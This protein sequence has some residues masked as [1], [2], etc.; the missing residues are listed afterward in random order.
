[1]P[2]PSSFK[3]RVYLDHHATTP[4]DPDVVQVMDRYWGMVGQPRLETE[5]LERAT[6]LV[7]T[8]LGVAVPPGELIWTSGATE[9]NNLALLG[10]VEAHGG[11]RNQRG[12]IIT[13]SIEHKSLLEPCR[14]LRDA[15]GW[16]VVELP[17]DPEGRVPSLDAGALAAS[18]RMGPTHVA[19]G[20]VNNEIGTIQ[21]IEGIARVCAKAGVPLHVDAAQAVG[22]IEI[23]IPPGVT[24]LALSGHKLYGPR[25]IGA[26]YVRQGVELE[27]I[28]YGGGQQGGLRSG[29]VPTPLVAGLGEAARLALEYLSHRPRGSERQHTDLRDLLLT[30]LT[31][32]LAPLEITPE[33]NG[34][35][36][37]PRERHPGNL[38]ITL[39]GVDAAALKDALKDEVQFSMGAAC[40]AGAPSHVLAAI[41]LTPDQ[42]ASTVRFGIGRHTTR[43]DIEIAARRVAEEIGHSR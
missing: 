16:N 36:L 26:L 6:E 32:L 42:V 34:P 8:L 41:G 21:D 29:T 4:T 12:I 18:A 23:A 39:P 5:A 10:M 7:S 31:E 19:I 24:T 2:Q 25:G 30:R 20:W 40:S 9:A 1:M 14:Y 17:V 13:T 43:D 35:D 3:P 28:M 22:N 37:D 11:R 33:L 15:W 38:N 27:P